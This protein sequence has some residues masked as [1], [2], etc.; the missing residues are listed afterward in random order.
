VYIK[1]LVAVV[2]AI[3]ALVMPAATQEAPDCPARTVIRKGCVSKDNCSSQSESPVCYDVDPQY[4]DEAAKANIKGTVRLTAS[5]GK[6][7]CAANIKVVDSLGYGLDE[8]AVSALERYRFH[9][10]AKP[11]TINVEFDFDPKFSSRVPV[12]KAKCK[13]TPQP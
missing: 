11:M 7:G 5:I 4:T 10:P 3:G 2:F 6:D 9:K 12:I 1:H 8:A 13:E